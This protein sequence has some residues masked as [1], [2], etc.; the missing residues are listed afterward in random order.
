MLPNKRLEE[1]EAQLLA[2]QDRIDKLIAA[3]DELRAQN[4]E[5][6]ELMEE[7]DI[8]IRLEDDILRISELDGSHC[9]EETLRPPPT[10]VDTRRNTFS[11]VD[12]G[13]PPL[14]GHGGPG[15]EAGWNAN[16]MEAV[17]GLRIAFAVCGECDEL[18]EFMI[19]PMDYEHILA[20]ILRRNGWRE[21]DIAIAIKVGVS[22]AVTR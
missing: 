19:G 20:P 17:H 6:E 10:H 1:L 15:Q 22:F 2:N 7:C 12:L 11:D 5:Q 14:P 16:V 9:S 21:T 8:D 4:A 13:F 18:L 3:N